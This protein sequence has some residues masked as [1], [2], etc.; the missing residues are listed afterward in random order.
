MWVR[1][2]RAYAN[3]SRGALQTRPVGVH[4]SVGVHA[5]LYRLLYFRPTL[6][7]SQPAV[8][9]SN[10]Q[11]SV[12]DQRLYNYRSAME[13]P[14]GY[15]QVPSDRLPTSRQPQHTSAVY[16]NVSWRVSNCRP[17]LTTGRSAL[18][19][20]CNSLPAEH[21]PIVRLSHPES[22]R[23]STGCASLGMA[24]TWSSRFHKIS[25]F[26]DFNKFEVACFSI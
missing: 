18:D 9:F 23:F 5:I 20:Q 22:M 7:H 4:L 26:Q 3:L 11:V 24:S 17:V 16:P 25:C 15:I 13:C 2:P 10:G 19:R 8:Q 6:Y 1:I 14:T 21:I 12:F